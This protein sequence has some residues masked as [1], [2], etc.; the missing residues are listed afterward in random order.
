MVYPAL[1]YL[2]QIRESRTG[3]SKQSQGLDAN[4]LVNQSATAVN[5]A[6]SASQARVRLIARIFAETG[7]RDL[8]W[9]LH[10]TIKKHADKTSVIR[11]RNQWVNVDPRNFR[12]RDDL[13]VHVGL[14]TGSRAEQVARLTII[15]GMQEKALL[16]KLPIVTPQN[17]YNTGVQL[18]KAIGHADVDAFFSDP[19]KQPPQPQQPDPEMV[20]AQGQMQ[21][22]AQKAQL[23]AQKSQADTQHQIAKTQA[24]MALAERKAQLEER[25]KLLD[26]ELKL[27]E[28]EMTMQKHHADMAAKAA[29]HEWNANSRLKDVNVALA[30]HGLAAKPDGTIDL[31]PAAK[32]ALDTIAQTIAASHQHLA[33]LIMAPRKSTL[34]RDPK[35]KRAIGATHEIDATALN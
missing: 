23:E 21:V 3:V 7:I 32:T 13:T 2:D 30:D 11:L 12:T 4:A 15:A 10:A 16:G 28:H 1:E 29:D 19:S 14:G 25:L 35:T 22:Q 33:K 9:L 31:H 20:K 6:F 34:H 27:K 26:A 17:A 24:D 18:T 5:Q 8:F